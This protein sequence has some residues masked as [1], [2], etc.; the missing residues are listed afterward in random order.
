MEVS[1]VQVSV[2][3]VKAVPWALG[4]PP[5]FGAIYSRWG[6][7]GSPFQHPHHTAITSSV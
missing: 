5:S 7:T 4:V 1:V 2:V 6:F 3:Q